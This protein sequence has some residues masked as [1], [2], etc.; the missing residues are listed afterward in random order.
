MYKNKWEIQYIK[1]QLKVKCNNRN[2]CNY[3]INYKDN[4]KNKKN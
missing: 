1:I 3:R 4:K 2:K